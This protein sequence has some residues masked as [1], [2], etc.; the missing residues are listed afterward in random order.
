MTN[1]IFQNPDPRIKPKNFIDF[2]KW[3]LKSK[4]PKWP[5]TVSISNYDIPPNIVE[6]DKIRISFVGHVTFLIQTQ[7]LNI[8]TDPVWSERVSPFSFVGPKR[9]TPPGIKLDQL[10]KIDMILISHNHYDHLDINTV[11]KLWIRN[12][13]RIIAPLMNNVTLKSRIPDAEVTTLDWSESININN[14]TIN[15]EPAQHWSARGIF[16]RN[17]ALWGNFIL[18]FQRGEICF[19]G[20]SGYN[21]NIYKSIGQK[22]RNILISLIPI[23][24]F[25]P[26]W[27][28][29]DIHIN[30]EEAILI[31]QDLNSKHSIGS[32][33]ETFQLADDEFDQPSRELAIAKKKYKISDEEFIAPRIGHFYWF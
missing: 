19:I 27:F 17:K 8:L 26:R 14:I 28:M 16:D 30:P 20:D 18:K 5:D 12:R 7:G 4:Q 2:L 3:K 32:H 10:P 33:F 21:S 25:E 24:A 29:K 31:H 13:P 1:R 22:Y 6:D 11:E 23:G 9:V 15:L